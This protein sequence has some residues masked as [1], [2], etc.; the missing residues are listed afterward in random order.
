MLVSTKTTYIVNEDDGYVGRL[1]FK[2]FF[3]FGE[4]KFPPS[5]RPIN[6]CVI[7]LT[8]PSSFWGGGG[9]NVAMVRPDGV[10]VP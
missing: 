5:P 9:G 6:M 10:L 7:L 2:F 4:A 8:G 1:Y 3:K